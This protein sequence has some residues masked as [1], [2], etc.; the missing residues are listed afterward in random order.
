MPRRAFAVVPCEFHRLSNPEK[1]TTPGKLGS[2]FLSDKEEA[3]RLHR[4]AGAVVWS[5]P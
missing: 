5:N 1:F 2:P 4:A 3:L